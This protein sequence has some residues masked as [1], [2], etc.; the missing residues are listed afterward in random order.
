MKIKIHI[1]SNR[2][3]ACWIGGNV[4]STLE[5]FKKMWITKHEWSDK[6]TKL[7]HTKTI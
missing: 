6:G 5:I 3:Y 4:I 1:P 2:K 7:I